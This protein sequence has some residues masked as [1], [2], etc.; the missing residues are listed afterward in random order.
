MLVLMRKEFESICIGN[1][2]RVCVVEI[3]NNGTVR[4]G[5]EAPKHVTVDREEVSIRKKQEQI[6]T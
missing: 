5:I 1:D 6:K 4:L 2:I 3:R